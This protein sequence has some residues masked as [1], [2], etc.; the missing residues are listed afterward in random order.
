MWQKYHHIRNFSENYKEKY[1]KSPKGFSLDGV[2]F[3]CLAF[4]KNAVG[5]IKAAMSQWERKTCIRFVERTNQ[6]NYLRF[7]RDTQ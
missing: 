2:L 1:R 5:A 7:K 3:R 4:L 6:K